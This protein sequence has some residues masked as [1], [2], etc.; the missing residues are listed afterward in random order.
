MIRMLEEMLN[1]TQTPQKTQLG[2]TKDIL[3]ALILA[4]ETAPPML[5][6]M[7]QKLKQELGEEKFNQLKQKY[8]NQ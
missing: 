6:K 4:D 2:D 7:Q 5:K 1:P 8:K 3:K